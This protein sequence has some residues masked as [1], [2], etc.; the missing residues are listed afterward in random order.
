MAK[1][2]LDGIR[3]RG[4]LLVL[5]VRASSSKYREIHGFKS[6]GPLKCATEVWT[7]VP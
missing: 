3:E 2:E 7:V 4:V 6:G 1:K 5:V